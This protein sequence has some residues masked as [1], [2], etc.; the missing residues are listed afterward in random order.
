M[1]YQRFAAGT[2]YKAHNIMFRVVSRDK[3]HITVR[4]QTKQY[5]RRIQKTPTGEEYIVIPKLNSN[6]EMRLTTSQKVVF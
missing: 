2:F 1:P 5:K 3:T 4:N 6:E